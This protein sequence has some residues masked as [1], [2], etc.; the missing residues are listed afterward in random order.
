MGM[1]DYVLGRK[2]IKERDNDNDGRLIANRKKKD[3]EEKE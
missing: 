2:K 1:F 3:K